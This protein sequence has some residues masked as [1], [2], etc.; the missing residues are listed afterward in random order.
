MGVGAHV[1]TPL[2]NYCKPAGGV[3]WRYLICKDILPHDRGGTEHAGFPAAPCLPDSM[4]CAAYPQPNRASDSPNHG[5]KQYSLP[6]NI[7]RKR[8]R[9]NGNTSKRF[10]AERKPL[11]RETFYCLS[12][13]PYPSG[14]ATHG[15]SCGNYNDW[16][17][18]FSA[19]SAC[20]GKNVLQT[21]GWDA[22]W[23]CRRKTRR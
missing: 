20:Q 14:K 12:H 2:W 22:V 17:M 5:K 1:K 13:V 3:S 21:L 11:I 6:A 16:R 9:P 15:P 7:E 19:I 23:G 4:P 18:L 10:K 8:P